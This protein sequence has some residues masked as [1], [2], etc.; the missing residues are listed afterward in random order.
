M[1]GMDSKEKTHLAITE[2]AIDVK[3]IFDFVFDPSCGAIASFIGA[4]RNNNL[5]REVLSVSYDIYQPLALKVFEK[6]CQEARSRFGRLNIAIIH[7]KG[8]LEIGGVSVAIAVSSKHR[9]EA[10]SACQFLIEELKHKAPIWKKEFYIDG[11]SE[12]IEGHKLCG[13]K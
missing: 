11:N 6:L 8:H 1:T 4:V 12:W 10:F 5:G 7:Y 2:E 13:H 3:N 9:K